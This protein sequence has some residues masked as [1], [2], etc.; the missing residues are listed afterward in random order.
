MTT[1]LRK[2]PNN[3]NLPARI[4]RLGELANNLWWVWNPQA[5]AL[6]SVIDARLWDQLNHNPVTLLKQADRAQLNAVSCRDDYLALYDSVMA[7]FDAYLAAKDTWFAKT[8]PK[9]NGR[10]IAY[11]SFEFGLH[12]SLPVYAGGL[13][14]LSGDH[15]KESSDLGIPLVGIGFI[16]RQGYFKQHITEDGWQNTGNYT[17]PLD[18]LPLIPL[19]DENKDPLMISLD[20][21]GRKV[22]ARIWEVQVG[23]CLLYLLDSDVD[24]NQPNDRQLTARLYSSDLDV[25]ISQEILLGIGGVKALRLLGLEPSVWHMNE[26][27]SAFLT[28]ERIRAAM[29]EGKSFDDAAKWVAHTDIFTTHTPVPAGQDQFPLWMIDK[30]L[31]G[32]WEELKLTRDQFIDLGRYQQSWGE[33]FSMPVL[34]LK[35]SEQ[36]NAVSQLH[37]KVSRRMWQSLWPGV[38]EEDVPI[39]SVTNGVHLS[40]WMSGRQQALFDRYLPADWKARI[41][42]AAVW[43]HLPEIPDEEFWAVHQ[44]L[45][46]DLFRFITR[47]VHRAWAE[48]RMQPV[49]VVAGGALLNSEKLT[50]GVARRFATYKRS[51]LIMQDYERLLSIINN[52]DMPVQIIFSGKAH[53]ADEPGKLIIQ[54]VYRAAKDTRTAGRIVFL[55]DYDMNVARHLVQGVDIWLNTPRRPNEASGTSGMKA[56]MNGV[57]NFSVRDG[58]WCEGYDGANGWKIGSEDEYADAAQEDRDDAEDIYH[59]LEDQIVPLFYKN[60]RGEIPSDDWI[61]M[62]KESIRTLAPQFSTTRMLKDYVSRMYIPAMRET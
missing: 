23:R 46:E 7:Q 61:R 14:I 41:D 3:F 55:E 11:F 57:L 60:W 37:G 10:R 13:G 25:R 42:D 18:E 35:L 39:T 38:G 32:L 21:P 6:F 12:E 29:Q 62:M 34:A 4:E 27:H 26:G 17:L 30:Y 40:S 52:P 43:A 56:A 44:R 31:A 28:L 49:Q 51:Y 24:I 8:Y 54:Q 53:P 50:I 45:K 19:L 9:L 1:I 2:V 5:R 22:Y 59:T 20:L 33:N 15:L 16:Y 36:R 48:G 58:W 47:R